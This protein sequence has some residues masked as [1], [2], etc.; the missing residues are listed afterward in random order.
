MDYEKLIEHIRRCAD[1]GDYPVVGSW[2]VIVDK[3]HLRDWA[4]ALTALLAEN[5]RLW[6][7]LEQVRRQRDSYRAYYWDLA[8]KPNC[9][10]CADRDCKYRPLPGDTVRANCPLWRGPED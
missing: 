7:E 10:T 8:Q 3:K 9:H 6:A 2:A 5:K 4:D 1:S